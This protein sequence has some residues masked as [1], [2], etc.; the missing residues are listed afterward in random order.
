MRK[1][2]VFI[3]KAFVISFLY[4]LALVSF[5]CLVTG[6]GIMDVKGLYGVD[7]IT[8]FL[9]GVA[10]CMATFWIYKAIKK[11]VEN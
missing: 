2:I 6:M 1:I 3:A 5:G 9:V 8:M 10:G 11:W 7:A 4:V